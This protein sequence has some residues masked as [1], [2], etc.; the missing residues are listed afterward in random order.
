MKEFLFAT[1][2]EEYLHLQQPLSA[3]PIQSQPPYPA[4]G[5]YEQ[6]GRIYRDSKNF[7][8]SVDD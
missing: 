1:I 3:G 7:S 2:S 4:R 6:N 5:F 8:S